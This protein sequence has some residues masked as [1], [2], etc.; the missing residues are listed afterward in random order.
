MEI[1]INFGANNYSSKE[2][3]T[4]KLPGYKIYLNPWKHSPNTV[5]YSDPPLD[6]GNHI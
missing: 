5:Q 2:R 3:H 6:L 4:E 1:I